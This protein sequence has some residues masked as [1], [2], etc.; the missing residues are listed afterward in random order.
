[1]LKGSLAAAPSNPLQQDVY[2]AATPVRKDAYITI[3]VRDAAPVF[4]FKER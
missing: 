3:T 4:H 1:V 2:Y